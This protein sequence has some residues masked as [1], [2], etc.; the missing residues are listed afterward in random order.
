MKILVTGGL[1]FIGSHTVDA[2]LKQGHR[3][4]ILDDLSTHKGLVPDWYNQAADLIV[5]DVTNPPTMARAM[6]GVDAIYHF[7]AYQDYLLDFSKFVRVNCVSTSLIYEIAVARKQALHKVIMA[8]SQAVYGEGEYCCSHCQKTFY[9]KAR[10]DKQLKTKQWNII[11]DCG[12]FAEYVLSRE[13][14]S[15]PYNQYALTKHAGELFALRTGER[16]D[17]PTV[18]MR[19]S[20]TQGIRQSTANGYSGALRVFTKALL[21]NKVPE[22]YEDGL[23]LRDYTPI[24]DVVQAN[25][26]VLDNPIANY[27]SFNVSSGKAITLN[28][29][30]RMILKDI[31]PIREGR[32]RYGDTRHAVSDIKGLCNLGWVPTG[33]L[34]DAVDEYIEWAK[35]QTH[36]FR[37][38]GEN[39]YMEQVGVIR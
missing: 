34:Q 19:Y 32:Y 29:Y 24:Q 10:K 17:I 12:H 8:S 35:T 18:A 7:A 14:F 23:Q 1:G 2:L 36:T 37:Y 5:G 28:Q 27:K 22:I 33:N 20:I 26:V 38:Y 16:F 11:C 3:V 13:T 6:L 25:L 31:E 21:N 15:N 39:E 9:P 30:A 4:V